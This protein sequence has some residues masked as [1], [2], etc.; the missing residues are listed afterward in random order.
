MLKLLG[1][2]LIVGSASAVG[3]GFAAN[4]RRQAAQ[5]T[6]LRQA[7]GQMKNELHC[8]MTPLPELL[9]GVGQDSPGA[10]GALFSACAARLRADRTGP[11]QAAFR[12]ALEQ[13]PQLALPGA[14]RRSLLSLSMTLGRFDVEG[15]CRAIDLAAGQ[16][17]AA[18]AELEQSRA[19]R[20][21]SYR[22]LG[23]CAGLAIAVILL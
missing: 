13:T 6:A 1:L 4:I 7:L 3:F 20:C 21:R 2:A 14:V 16:A 12:S 8:R 10:V 19:A 9:D 18:L 17:E 22:T 5:L 11:V 23:I 15:Q